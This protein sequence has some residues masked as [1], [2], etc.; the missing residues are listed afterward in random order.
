M[1]CTFF[2]LKKLRRVNNACEFNLVKLAILHLKSQK[3]CVKLPFS[4]PE[5]AARWRMR[6][7]SIPYSGADNPK[8]TT[9]QT[10]LL[11]ESA[12]KAIPSNSKSGIDEVGW[13]WS[14]QCHNGNLGTY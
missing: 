7:K 11:N 14:D 4:G 13:P 5:W 8:T 3:P 10:I 12:C 6:G 2:G 9:S 1:F